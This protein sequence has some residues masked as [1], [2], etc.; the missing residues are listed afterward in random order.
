MGQIKALVNRLNKKKTNDPYVD[1]NPSY[2]FIASYD[3]CILSTV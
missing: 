3:F 2:L 1:I